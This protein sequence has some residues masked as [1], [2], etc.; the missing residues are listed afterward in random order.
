MA[1]SWF[2]YD[3]NQEL[4]SKQTSAARNLWNKVMLALRDETAA[5]NFDAYAG[6]T[7]EALFCYDS[8]LLATDKCNKKGTGVYKPGHLPEACTTHGGTVIAPTTPPQT[9]ATPAETT[10]TTAPAA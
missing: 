1:A 8:G 2:G 3:K 10:T 9:T 5:K 6:T 4:T 7:V